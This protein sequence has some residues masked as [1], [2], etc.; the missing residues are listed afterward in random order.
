MKNQRQQ[1][2]YLR[3]ETSP[4]LLQHLFNPVDWYPWGQEALEKAAR[5][6]KP[7]LVSIGYSACHWCHVME[8]ES[9]QDE[10]VAEIMNNY[11]VCI[12]V[13]REER[14]DID[15]MYMTAVQLLGGRGGWPL[16]CFALPDSR[17]FWGSTY[18]PREHW[19][20][21]LA[22]VQGLYRE[23]KDE[24]VT[25]AENLTQGISQASFIKPGRG[26]ADF[27]PEDAVK[28]FNNIIRHMDRKE[29]GTTGAPKFPL[30]VNLEFLLHYHHQCRNEAALQQVEVT[31]E[32]MALGGI[33]DQVG[34]GFARYSTDEKWKV[35]HF[36]KM[37]Y[38]NGQLVSLYSNAFKISGNPLFRHVVYQTVEFV[39]RELTAPDGT[40]Y[41][42]LDADSEGQEGKFYVWKEEEID[43]IIPAGDLPV[44]REYYQVGKKGLWEDGLNILLRDEGDA[45]F[46]RRMNI[47]PAT[48][49]ETMER[50][51]KLLLQARSQR[52][53]PGLDNKV[54]ASWN[55]LMIHGLADAFA[56]FGDESFLS[57]AKKAAGFLMESHITPGGKLFRSLRGE[58]SPIDGFLED[59]ALFIRALIRLWEVSMEQLFLQK[60]GLLAEYVITNF[61]SSSTR[62]F[63]FSSRHGESLKT[64][65]FEIYDNVIPSSN[66]VMAINLLHLANYFEN[67]GWSRRSTNILSDMEPLLAEQGINLANWGRLLLY[68]IHP[69]FTL[70]ICG[71]EARKSVNEVNRQFLP[72]VLV[73]GTTDESDIPVFRDRV[74]DGETWFYLCSMGSCKMPVQDLGAALEQAKKQEG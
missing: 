17:P 73:A 60:A 54:L 26:S 6:D 45:E 59:Y 23:R 64:D 20:D 72:N 13:D 67:P 69:L 30:P 2:N 51:R 8:K 43:A 35:P 38:D 19:I 57:R 15:H 42:A 46:C 31:L 58:N 66:S 44:V 56:A 21:I 14:P 24:L 12:K 11:F 62:L 36:E 28:V 53:R 47:S 27:Q 9:F 61:T 33:Y 68:N 29:G 4:Y 3:G 37:L 34:G 10:K 49:R 22:Q 41:S 5:E 74:R 25:Q 71:P 16:N 63:S 70:A 32:K 40:F 50:T 39:D 1:G 55:A 65:H 48:L 52:I 7:V 18:L